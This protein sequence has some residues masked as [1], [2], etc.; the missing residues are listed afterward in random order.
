MV[1]KIKKSELAFLVEGGSL[2]W[3]CSS[4]LYLGNIIVRPQIYF[5]LKF[6]REKGH[7]IFCKS[8]LMLMGS[9]SINLQ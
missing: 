8:C 5:V 4:H 6:L 7:Y 3:Q 9:L 1:E 2:L